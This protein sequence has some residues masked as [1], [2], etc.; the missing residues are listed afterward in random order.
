M[1][2]GLSSSKIVEDCLV[3]QFVAHAAVER[4]ANPIL[5]RLARS[6]EMPGDP[7]ALS[8]GE[9]GVGCEL[10][11]VIGDDQVGLAAPGDDG[12]EFARHAP[13]RDRGVWNRR[14]A[15][16]GDIV[17]QVEDAE[18]PTVRKLVV[19]EVDRPAS[20][21]PGLDEDRRPHAR[22]PFAALALAHGQPLLAVKPLRLLSV[23]GMALGAQE[24]MQPAIAKPALLGR[25]LPQPAAQGVVSRPARS[26]THGLAIGLDQAARPA[27]AHLVDGYEMSDS[28]ALGGG[29]Q[30]FF[31][32]RSFRAALSSIASARSRFSLAFSS[33]SCL[34]RLASETSIPP[35]LAFQ[36]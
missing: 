34:S 36:A 9:H 35:N 8:P 15:L 1:S 29:R 33:S 12:V 7:A 6:D 23:H 21:W 4:L 5:C 14:Q 20:V 2:F 10:G 26:I 27:L 24:N 13:T 19:D 31:V 17:D 18:A 22:R 28:L 3:E 32:R 11:P 16:L 30:N 25:Q